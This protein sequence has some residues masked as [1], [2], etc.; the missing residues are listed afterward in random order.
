MQIIQP[1]DLESGYRTFTFKK[2]HHLVITA[3]LH[4]PLLGGDPLLFS[5]AYEAMSEL[6]EFFI[7][8]GLP[9]LTPE[10]FTIGNAKSLN[11]QPV[12]ALKVKT[13][14][15]DA[16]KSAHV[17][18]DRYWL[19]GIT[20]TSKP[21]PFTEMPIIWKNAFGGKDFDQNPNGKGIE[22]VK[23]DLGEELVEMPNIE[24]S[25][26]LL[27]GLNQRP[28]PAGFSSVMIDH[29][30]RSQYLGTYDEN[31]LAH[32]F[33]G[34][35]KD[36]NFKGFN[37]APKD[38]QLSH[39]LMG[40]EEFEIENMHETYGLIKGNIPDFKARSFLVK[41][42]K[43]LSNLTSQDLTEVNLKVD[44][45][46][47]YPNQLFGT[48]IYRGTIKVEQNDASDYQ[49]IMSSYESKNTSIRSKDHYFQSLVGRLHPDLNMQYALTTKDLIPDD[50]PC[51][52]ARLTQQE[53]EP[54]QL[55]AEHIE[56]RMSESVSGKIDETAEQLKAL[57]LDA[58]EK[59]QDTSSLEQQLYNLKN[60]VKDEWQL[61]FEVVTN[62]LAPMAEDG[63]TVDLHKIDFRAFD[64]LSKLSEEYAEFQKAQAQ[65]NLEKQ[66]SDALESDNSE[67]AESL[68]GA[69]D[70]F[71]A[72][73]ELPRPSDYKAMLKQL[74]QANAQ[75]PTEQKTDIAVI[76]EKLET[77]HEMQIEGYR[78][79]A[80]MMDT[81]TPPKDK[82]L[83]SIR[84]KALQAIE[85]GQ[86]L[87]YM[88]LAGIDFSGLD[89]R[90]AD[91]SHCYLEQCNFHYSNLELANF[92][93]AIAVRCNFSHANLTQANLESANI[94]ASN[95]NQATLKMANSVGCE[96]AKAD[97]SNA[98]LEM[99]DLSGTINTLDVVFKQANLKG[100]KFGNA[101]FLETDFHGAD[102]TET[103]CIEATFNE[104]NLSHIQGKQSQFQ[105]CNFISC[106]LSAIHFEKSDFTNARFLETTN[107]AEAKFEQC[108]LADSTAR[109]VDL[110]HT[111]FINCTLNNADFSESNLEHSDFNGCTIKDAIFVNTNL[112]HSQL[113]NVNFMFSNFM[114][115][116]L[117]KS[118]ISKSNLYGCEFLG[119]I[120]SKTDFSRSNLDGTKLE[121][122]RP[123]KWQ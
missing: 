86:S 91:F 17:T 67:M 85:D 21:V 90:G 88:D 52:M 14:L 75:L 25:G 29:P 82:D 7:D 48:L 28:T 94:G 113:S 51:G 26:Q 58:K 40:S 112:Q 73:P 53:V 84:T 36:F 78:I 5:E 109:K 96:F 79:S 106:S 83:I 23:S 68:Q 22:K 98:N 39:K 93:K 70:R 12:P 9:K 100:V 41:P 121:N 42:F 89:L 16:I 37:S 19:G 45:V 77:A 13:K 99:L 101:T 60:P 69:L 102:F 62:K 18:G 74:E 59:G 110:N 47:F 49:Y 71:Q 15:C 30:S 105:G 4:F 44:T 57:I 118:N 97:F 66:I 120:V 32:D 65:L 80:H 103:Q 43:D 76:K 6:E 117:S 64:E 11:G 1:L 87:A 122:W 55:L 115:A 2:E 95:F 31:W 54:R 81:G 8:E 10:F 27:T 92:H 46:V 107:L 72:P 108:I 104:C 33:P 63:K 20:G 24:Y 116:D 56:K 38:Q 34:Y 114:Q 123:S 111:Q 119:S 3:K 61:K 50:I 35:P